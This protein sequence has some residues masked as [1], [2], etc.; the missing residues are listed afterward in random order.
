MRTVCYDAKPVV[1]GV[2]V[3]GAGASLQAHKPTALQYSNIRMIKFPGGKY[4]FEVLPV[5][6]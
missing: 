4:F 5:V 3:E 1:S 6:N 2:R